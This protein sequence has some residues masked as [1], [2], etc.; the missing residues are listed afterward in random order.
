MGGVTINRLKDLI[1]SEDASAICLSEFY[2]GRADASANAADGV[3]PLRSSLLPE[4]SGIDTEHMF[5]S[6]PRPS[7][8][9]Q[10]Y[11][12]PP[13]CGHAVDAVP[14]LLM[15]LDTDAMVGDF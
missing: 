9:Q 3:V 8:S 1:L 15:T 11:H 5:L 12:R 7:S 13:A 6:T 10:C 4:L 2:M 14:G